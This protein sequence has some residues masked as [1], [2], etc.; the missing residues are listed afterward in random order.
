M[1]EAV[2]DLIADLVK[3]GVSAELV[4]R[5]AAAIVSANDADISA[6]KMRTE[7]GQDRRKRL[8]RE[9]KRRARDADKSADISADIADEL[10]FPRQRNAP[11][12]PKENSTQPLQKGT[13]KGS[14][15]GSR[16]SRIPDGFPSQTD[17]ATIDEPAL[18][19]ADIEREAA[20]FRDYWLGVPGERGRKVDWPATWRNW[21]RKAA[22]DRSRSRGPPR[23]R[24]M[25][26]T[27]LWL[28][29]RMN[30]DADQEP[31]P[32]TTFLFEQ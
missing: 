25:D 26:A 10:P 20:K 11:T 18:S 15:K 9:R 7:S 12:P 4:G 16:G 29:T 19:G 14:Q 2:A 3:A 31:P 24:R 6:D 28:E 27:D 23:G 30:P 13:L 32:G 5:V 8:D 17:E 22:E 1:A 21:C